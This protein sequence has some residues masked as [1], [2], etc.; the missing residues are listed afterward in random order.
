MENLMKQVLT[1]VLSLQNSITAIQDEMTSMR[2]DLAG[3]KAKTD[4]L[5]DLKSEFIS[6]KTT[7]NSGFDGLAKKIDQLALEGQKD[8]IA[9]L[10]LMDKKLERT[11][12]KIDIID[13]RIAAQDGEIRLLKLAK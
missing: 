6:V 3:V 12:T 2:Q 4:E 8:I 10:A 13:H 11:E 1:T 7:M 9:M 5:P